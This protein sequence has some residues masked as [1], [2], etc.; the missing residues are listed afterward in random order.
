MVEAR[1]MKLVA[2]KLSATSQLRSTLNTEACRI[3]VTSSP[4][5]TIVSITIQTVGAFDRVPFCS[6]TKTVIQATVANDTPITKV[7]KA[8][9]GGRETGSSIQPRAGSGL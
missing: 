7:R 3:S 1:Q 4:T 5:N 2:R 9:S 8:R 6:A